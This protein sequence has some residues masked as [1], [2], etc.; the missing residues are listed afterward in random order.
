MEA[1]DPTGGD[2]FH[3]AYFSWHTPQSP[4]HSHGNSSF[5]PT[6]PLVTSPLAISMGPDLSPQN[7]AG[8]HSI[9]DDK[10]PL[11]S[12]RLPPSAS[13]YR[14]NES[15]S[16][17]SVVEFNP[18]F[19]DPF[20]T[21]HRRRT[22]KSEQSR[23][24]AE[25]ALNPKPCTKIREQLARELGMTPRGVQIW[26]QNRRA[27]AKA[28]TRKPEPGA[29][30]EGEQ[31]MQRP[32]P[33]LDDL[34]SL[35]L[36]AREASMLNLGMEQAIT[37]TADKFARGKKGFEQKGEGMVSAQ[38]VLFPVELLDTFAVGQPPQ[39]PVERRHSIPNLAPLDG[40]PAPYAHLPYSPYHVPV[41]ISPQPERHRILRVHSADS[42]LHQ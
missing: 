1:K 42:A 31:P 11:Q 8:P 12:F 7:S 25:Y 32:V 27:K 29:R 14:L 34:S 37:R 30:V 24:E 36:A 21:R 26:F 9:H 13:S 10:H 28:S 15:R 39:P 17:S 3:Q 33:K 16:A 22:S 6:H 2:T 19:Y 40:S 35:Q 20:K 23:L 5:P 38:D 4:H 18:T 41:G